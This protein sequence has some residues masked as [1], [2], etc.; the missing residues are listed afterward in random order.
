MP[1]LAAGSADKK[2][3]ETTPTKTVVSAPS[4]R[5]R[6]LQ[7]IVL[8]FDDGFN[9]WHLI[10]SVPENF[11]SRTLNLEKDILDWAPGKKGLAQN[12]KSLAN[13]IYGALFGSCGVYYLIT[14]RNG[15]DKAEH[16]APHI[17][18]TLIIE[19]QLDTKIRGSD[20]NKKARE[21]LNMF[22]RL[23]SRIDKFKKIYASY[24]DN[25]LLFE[26]FSAFSYYLSMQKKCLAETLKYTSFD[27]TVVSAKASDLLL[28]DNIVDDKLLDWH[29][30]SIMQETPFKLSTPYF[31]V[32]S[33]HP[34]REKK[35]R[36]EDS[37]ESTN[38]FDQNT[39]PNQKKP[40]SSPSKSSSTSLTPGFAAARVS[41]SAML[42][43]K[44]ENTE[45]RLTIRN[46]KRD[47]NF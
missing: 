2:N 30:M 15:I 31:R 43:P 28:K 5:Q 7:Q 17:A 13:D 47:F 35:V 23:L 37:E 24:N 14:E 46:L 3:S 42:A 38:T 19:K 10:T 11:K 21:M 20:H 1:K 33:E 26:K 40:H 32:M 45:E 6:Y 39:S 41:L 12:Y 27:T 22:E 34:Q 25:Q 18:Q 9:L 36:T 16:F 29:P 8:G 4:P 44:I